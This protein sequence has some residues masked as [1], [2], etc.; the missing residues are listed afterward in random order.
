MIVSI[1]SGKGGT[2]KTTVA[3]SL[4]LAA[5]DVTLLDADVEE[6]NANI[7]L[8]AQ[9]NSVKKA[10]VPFP[11]IDLN[12]CDFCEECS[13]FCA[14]NA[15]VVLKGLKVFAVPEM[16]KS[17]GGCV[18]VCP[19]KAIKE[20]P[21][22]IGYIRHGEKNKIKFIDGDLNVGESFATPLIRQLF[23]FVVGGDIIV[24]CPP[25]AAHPM[26]ESVRRADFVVLV[27]EPT[28]F[29]IHDLKEALIITDSL[30]KK[31]G[32]V[33]NRA[34]IGDEE[35]RKLAK[36]REIPIL[37]EIPYDDRI[38]KW[39]SQGQAPVA[40]SSE[41]RDKFVELWRKIKALSS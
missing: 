26:V 16:C 2:G 12:K 10:T 20:V 37:A 22:E 14:Y 9:I 40:M 32:I 27:T 8:H 38:A 29:G 17:C 21:R 39:Y 35:V 41:W 3:V 28:P 15:I 1:A 24:D 11:E 36:E 7:L 13:K 19:Q 30:N 4:A 18:L 23:D 5:Q 6:P 25:G 31:V 34:D 33:V